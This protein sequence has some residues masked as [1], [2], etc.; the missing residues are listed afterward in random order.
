M[1]ANGGSPRCCDKPH[2]EIV[3]KSLLEKIQ[4][5]LREESEM[6]IYDIV[7]Y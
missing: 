7:L 4:D 6:P 3:P 5:G 2:H 1:R